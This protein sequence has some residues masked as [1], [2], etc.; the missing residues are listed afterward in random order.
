MMV[1]KQ[2]INEISARY[3]KGKAKQT[4]LK[5]KQKVSWSLDAIIRMAHWVCGILKILHKFV[6]I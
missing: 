5:T 2:K 3:C 1:I 4:R 6:N